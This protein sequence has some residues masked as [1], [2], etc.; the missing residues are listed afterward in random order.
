MI[1]SLKWLQ[2]YFAE[3]LPSAEAVAEALTFHACEIEEIKGDILDVKVLPDRAAY[4][5][6]HRGIATEV[7]AA[8]GVP[9]KRDP[10]REPLPAWSSTDQLTISIETDK[11]ARQM[12][13]LVRGVKVG[14]SPAWL[15]EALESIGQRSINNIVDAT[16]FVTFDI[17]QPLHAFDAKKIHSENGALNITIRE[18]GEGEKVTTLSGDDFDLP[19]GTVVIAEVKGEEGELGRPL[20]IA[21]VKGG[22]AS[23]ITEDTTDLYVSVA[24]FDG[25]SIRKTAQKLKL[26]TDAS[27]RFQNRPSPELTA[28]GMR[29]V[30]RLIQE[31]AGGELVGVVDVYPEPT[32]IVPVQVSLERLNSYLGTDFT[33]EDVRTALDRL[34]FTYSTTVD[35]LYIVTPHFE[36]RDIVIPEDLIEEIGRIIGYDRV[37]SIPLTAEDQSVIPDQN[38]YHGIERIK[39]FLIDRGFTELS[40]Q[41]FATAG[42][43]G[44]ANPLDQTKPALRAGLAENMQN[45]LTRAVSVAPRV[46][47]PA[48]EIKLFEI[49]T[50]FKKD[51]EYLSLVLGYKQLVGKQSATLLA[52]V[53]SQLEAEMIGVAAERP[54]VASAEVTEILLADSNLAQLG[55]SYAP[56]KIRAGAYKSFSIYPFALRDIAVW[57]PERT[58]QD[59]VSNII[60]GIAEQEDFELARIDLFDRFSKV[61]DGKERISYAFRLVFESFER[62]LSDEDLNPLMDKITSALNATVTNGEQWEVR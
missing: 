32:E 38:K 5:L 17:G 15:R 20:D 48:S 10:L 57:T 62:T 8:L 12:G 56:G 50:V 24:N 58:E 22:V 47:G 2:T 59:E 1:V 14:P 43:I 31:I 37:P 60:I 53:I 4:A 18:T 3:P 36:R 45:A 54:A 26:W 11:T 52:E 27:L 30:L 61:I 23:A 25:T 16:N 7:A 19:K 33:S 42:E 34:A 55:A 41:T 51:A 29:D 39:D 28:Y 6:S 9:M 40:T 35:D 46:L 13:A 49:G 21:G 44:L